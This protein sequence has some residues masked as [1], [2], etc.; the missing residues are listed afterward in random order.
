MTAQRRLAHENAAE[1]DSHVV[2]RPRRDLGC[3]DLTLES[4]GRQADK[5]D[6][7]ADKRDREML[8]ALRARHQADGL[9]LNHTPGPADP[10]LWIA[11]AVVGAVVASRTGQPR[12]C[13]RLEGTI[14]VVE[15][16]ET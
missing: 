10:V 6:R 9:R 7:Q 14:T 2:P 13:L 5:R 11:D 4:R 12:W 15:V 3:L 1:E 16:D 8:D